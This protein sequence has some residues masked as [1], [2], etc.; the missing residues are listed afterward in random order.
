MLQRIVVITP[1]I[2]KEPCF[3]E[4]VMLSSFGTILI[5]S[6]ATIKHAFYMQGLYNALHN[7]VHNKVEA[8]H[9]H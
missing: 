5:I 6:T 9:V 1:I 4:D 8:S 2:Y 7:L 3:T